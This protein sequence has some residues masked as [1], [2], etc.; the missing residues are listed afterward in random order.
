MSTKQKEQRGGG[1]TLGKE[2]EKQEGNY[3]ERQN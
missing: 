2:A 1:G 3:I